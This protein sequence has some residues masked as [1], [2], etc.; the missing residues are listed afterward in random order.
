MAFLPKTPYCC[1]CS[2][3]DWMEPIQDSDLLCSPF[4]C[5]D[6]GIKLIQEFLNTLGHLGL[7]A[8]LLKIYKR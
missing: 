3:C 7:L 8:K 2:Q 5:L 4:E 1:L 6:C